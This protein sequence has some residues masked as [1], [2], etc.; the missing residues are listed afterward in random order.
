[1]PHHEFTWEISN[2]KPL[3]VNWWKAQKESKKTVFLI[4]GLGEHSGRYA[5]WALRFNAHDYN[6]LSF[7]LP[8]HG[9]SY[10]KRG[11]ISSL[12]NIL[13][14]I[15]FVLKKSANF[16]QDHNMVF[17]GHSMGGNIALNHCIKRNYPFKALIITSPWLKLVSK[18][19]GLHQ[20]LI[21][22]AN[23]FA[24]SI[25]IKIP[26]N[27]SEMT[28]DEAIMK[29]Y[30]E[31]PLNH[32]RISVRLFHEMS[33][34]AQT[35]LSNIYKINYPFL[36]MHGSA[37]TITSS[38]ASKSYVLNTGKRIQFKLWEGQFH[39]LHNEATREEVFNYIIQWL[40]QIDR[41]GRG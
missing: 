40:E 16:C 32:G 27:A 17:Y 23:R 38:K 11:H 39:E 5:D 18:P 6:F 19:S 14:H 15:D 8:G 7:D 41:E 34:G 9:K 37:D 13:D 4:H 30:S 31:D 3:F 10:G 33:Q 22:L 1:M 35:A 36:L 21:S 28:H 12:E 2:Q 25:T 20:L 29:S 24:P 26:F